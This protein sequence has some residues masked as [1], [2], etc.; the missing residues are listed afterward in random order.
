MAASRA[1]VSLWAALLAFAWLGRAQAQVASMEHEPLQ[2][3][4][5]TGPMLAPSAATLP[6]GHILI[7][8]YL[9]DVTTQGFYD[10]TGKR[11]S[12]PHANGFG[13]LTYMLYGVTNRL[14]VGL[15]PTAGY[16]VVSGGSSS[17]GPAFGDVSLQGE[18]RLRNFHEGSWLPTVS[19]AVQQSLPT[20]KYDDL[21]ARPAN[22]LGSG[23]YS[24]TVA[25][26]S[27]TYFWLSNGR[28]LRVRLNLTQSFSASTSVRGVSVYGT[29]AGFVGHAQPGAASFVDV[30]WEYSVTRKWVLAL[31]GTYRYQNNT[32]AD[33]YNALDS[34]EVPVLLNSGSS[35][36][37]GFAPAIEY[38][39]NSKLGVLLGT[40]FIA[41]G[42]NAP[43]TI[44]P[45]I[46]I[47]FVH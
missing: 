25:L 18:Y 33:G 13:S 12:A 38:N 47:N 37:V 26:Y 20:A 21:G 44:S 39:L 22:G 29:D 43:F 8:P 41:A 19:F 24:T 45:A 16:N 5:F 6:K 42:R 27:Q 10:R 9:Y 11:L 35:D 14:T 7:E 36:A 2:D 17:S 31:D 1:V 40:R 23:A 46:A 4:W 32:R 3:A 30:S 15:I 34:P 28:I